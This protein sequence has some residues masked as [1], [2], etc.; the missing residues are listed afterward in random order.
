MKKL[1]PIVCLLLACSLCLWGCGNGAEQS[2]KND[3]DI[4]IESEGEKVSPEWQ[5]GPEIDLAFATGADGRTVVKDVNGQ[6]I[7]DVTEYEQADILFDEVSGV[8]RCVKT[9]TRDGEKMVDGENDAEYAAYLYKYDYYDTTGKL[10]EE[11]SDDNILG[12]IDNTAFCFYSTDSFRYTLKNLAS[13][14]VLTSAADLN[15][16]VSDQGF[17]TVNPSNKVSAFWSDNGKRLGA[18]GV[19]VAPVVIENNFDVNLENE[20][21]RGSNKTL[22]YGHAPIS[23]LDDNSVKSGNYKSDREEELVMLS[24]DVGADYVPSTF[25]LFAYGAFD[26]PEAVKTL[27]DSSGQVLW[28][29]KDCKGYSQLANGNIVVHQENSTQVLNRQTLEPEKTLDFCTAY[30]DGNNAVKQSQVQ[31][32]YLTDGDGKVLS[33]C[34]TQIQRMDCEDDAG[35]YFVGKRW[36]SWYQD[37]LD[38]KGQV[39]FTDEFEGSFYGLGQGQFFVESQ[40]GR[41]IVDSKGQVV[42]MMNLSDGYKYADGDIEKK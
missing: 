5:W 40:A 18:L 19:S 1:I 36:N 2:E 26:D 32:N 27:V 4:I 13:G 8:C 9:Y 17:V 22:S 42:E 6:E 31:Y 25:S 16:Y 34:Y 39:L 14:K 37:V 7:L 29:A 35:K 12:I 41:Y 38:D 21:F 20:S 3:A 15:C 10:L 28:E 30:Y 33:E 24:K 11:A 23:E